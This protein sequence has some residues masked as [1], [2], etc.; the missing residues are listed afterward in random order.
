MHKILINIVILFLFF[1]TGCPVWHQSHRHFEYANHSINVINPRKMGYV[2]CAGNKHRID[3][4]RM[5]YT[6]RHV[7]RTFLPL[8]VTHC[9]ELDADFRQTLISSD[10]FVHVMNLCADSAFSADNKLFGMERHVA[11][12]K[13]RGFFCKV[14]ALIKSPLLETM[15]L[16]LDTIWFRNPEKLFNSRA[17][18]KNKSLFFRDRLYN[19]EIHGGRI[20]PDEI[21][22]MLSVER[23]KGYHVDISANDKRKLFL[24]NG[25][26][27]YFANVYDPNFYPQY[28][29]HQDSSTVIIDKQQHPKLMNRLEE[30][31]GGFALGYGD[32]EMFWVAATLVN[33]SYSWE[34]FLAGQYGDCMGL[35]I[36]FDPDDAYL[37]NPGHGMPMYMNAEYMVEARLKVVGDF[38]QYVMTKP[39]LATQAIRNRSTIGHMR[40]FDM[41]FE[42]SGCTCATYDCLPLKKHVN[43]HVLLAQWIVISLRQSKK[44]PETDCIPIYVKHIETM[45]KIFQEKIDQLRKVCPLIGCPYLPMLSYNQTVQDDRKLM[46][47]EPVV[48]TV[49]IDENILL[50]LATKARQQAYI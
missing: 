12:K 29:E 47:C 41:P 31:L 17:Y 34:P 27:M 26:N 33:E 13:L 40:S 45:N 46:I 21:L 22:D 8:I 50:K 7:W 14:A 38:M 37:K 30:W 18:L 35:I 5:I 36:Q 3:V 2:V 20:M 39:I 9:N 44:G 28:N 42:Y 1:Q 19:Y 11:E 49:A 24:D 25:V 4:M 48:Y 23:G 43:F 32:K 10:P 6:L 15:L 16:D